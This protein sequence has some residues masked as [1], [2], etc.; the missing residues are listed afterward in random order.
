MHHHV[1]AVPWQELTL[2]YRVNCMIKCHGSNTYGVMNKSSLD[3]M[4]PLQIVPPSPGT[5]NAQLT[6]RCHETQLGI[7]VCRFFGCGQHS[8][9]RVSA[10]SATLVFS[11]FS[12]WLMSDPRLTSCLARTIGIRSKGKKPQKDSDQRCAPY[13]FGR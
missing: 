9:A 7:D 3:N 4:A 11:G 10:Q 5:L 8:P 13:H 12:P 6:G 2:E 1:K